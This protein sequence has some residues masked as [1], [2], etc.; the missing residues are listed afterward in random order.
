M[1]PPRHAAIA[2]LGIWVN[3]QRTNKNKLCDGR[4]RRLDELGARGRRGSACK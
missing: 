4:K 1:R 3:G 2:E